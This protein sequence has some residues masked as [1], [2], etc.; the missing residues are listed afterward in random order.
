M[1]PK[2]QTQLNIIKNYLK[3]KGSI[4]RNYCLSIFISRLG[5][6]IKTLQYEGWEL[7]GKKVGNDYV[8]T[9]KT[10]LHVPEVKIVEVNE[11]GIIRRIAKYV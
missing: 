10:K 8:Y 1:T 11:N 4:S 3:V 2:K 5:A 9:L 7:E 6:H